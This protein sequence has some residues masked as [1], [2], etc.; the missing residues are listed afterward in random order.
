MA[1]I[2]L[3]SIFSLKYVNEFF[4]KA[5]KCLIEVCEA[6]P[7]FLKK[8]WKEMMVNL[9]AVIEDKQLDP[10]NGPFTA[11]ECAISYIERKPA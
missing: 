5:L 10:Y 2:L 8:I 1:N 6:D 3:N 4:D 9:L 7:I 11:L